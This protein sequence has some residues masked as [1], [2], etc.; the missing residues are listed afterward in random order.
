MRTLKHIN[1]LDSD[2]VRDQTVVYNVI[3]VNIK[4][5]NNGPSKDIRGPSN[6]T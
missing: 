3:A 1:H 2:K 6:K 5:T 4:Y